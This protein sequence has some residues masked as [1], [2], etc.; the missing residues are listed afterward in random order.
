MKEIN[1]KLILLRQLFW[2]TINELLWFIISLSVDDMAV[3]KVGTIIY[4]GIVASFYHGYVV[5]KEED[6]YEQS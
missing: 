3:L 5:A 6:L 4:I 1:W 2:F